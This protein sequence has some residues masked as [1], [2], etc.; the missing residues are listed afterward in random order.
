MLLNAEN[1]EMKVKATLYIQKTTWIEHE[2]EVDISAAQST[3][4]TNRFVDAFGNAFNDWS[5]K[6]EDNDDPAVTYELDDWGWEEID[7]KPS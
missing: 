5:G 3:D 6:Q 2:V 4:D 7:E 1:T